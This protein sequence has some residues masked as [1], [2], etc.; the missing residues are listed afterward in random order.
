MTDEDYI[1]ANQIKL[2]QKAIDRLLEV[3]EDGDAS[4]FISTLTSNSV[5][6]LAQIYGVLEDSY[7]DYV[8]A[9][10]TDPP[11]VGFIGGGGADAA[12]TATLED[13]ILSAVTVTNPGTGYTS[14]PAIV[15]TDEDGAGAAA[16]AVLSSGD[17]VASVTVV[18]QSLVARL[19]STKWELDAD[20]AAI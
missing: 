1:L 19:I 13:G 7:E 2:R 11:T 8:G 18:H 14:T 15:F 9:L 20:F 10:Y 16:V 17:T 12:G 4:N 3:I 6:D 5:A